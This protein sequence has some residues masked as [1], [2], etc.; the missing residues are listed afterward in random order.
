MSSPNTTAMHDKPVSIIIPIYNA[1]ENLGRCL[2]SITEQTLLDIEII[3]IDDGSDDGSQFLCDKYAQKDSRIKVVHT[4]HKGTASACNLGIN[5]SNGKY[6][7]FVNPYDWVEKQMFGH[8]YNLSLKSKADVVTSPY[9]LHKQN[10]EIVI[11]DDV[12]SINAR[13][14][15]DKKLTNKFAI[16]GFYLKSHVYCCSIYKKDF[17]TDNKIT[18][19]PNNKSNQSLAFLFL[20]YCH[21]SVFYI[22]RASFYHHFEYVD[23]DDN[24]FIRATELLNEHLYISEIIE[25]YSIPSNLAQIEIAKLFLDIN[26]QL[27]EG[28]S[29]FKQRK[30]YLCKASPIFNKYIKFFN[31]NT[32]LSKYEKKQ[33]INYAEH[34]EIAAILNRYNIH[35]KI[36]RYLFNIQ[37]KKKVSYIR[38][39]NFPIVFIKRT[40]EYR[41]CNIFN[42][43]IRRIR[44]TTEAPGKIKTRYHYIGIPLLKR[45]DTQEEI[46]LYFAGVRV[47]KKINIQAQLTAIIHR[48]NQLPDEIHMS[49]LSDVSNTVSASHSKTFPQ[50]KNSNYGKSIAI[51][52]TGPSIKYSPAIKNSKTIACNRAYEYFVDKDPTYIFAEDYF[53][54]SGFFEEMVKNKKSNIFLGCY[55]SHRGYNHQSIPEQFLNGENIYRYYVLFKALNIRAELEYNPIAVFGTVVHSALHFALY[56]NPETIYLL[57]CDT[58]SSGYSNKNLIQFPM[59]TSALIDGYTKFRAFRDAQYPNTRIVSVNPIGLRGIFED[60]YTEEFVKNNTEIDEFNLQLVNEI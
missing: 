38:I 43:P 18:F 33:L 35:M 21:M 16:T 29:S 59:N 32:Y 57:G 22:T 55:V 45:I 13:S 36:L 58:S 3:L 37:I 1:K 11:N 19:N 39:F 24:S 47:Y 27:K 25:K 10:G 53:G 48:L 8:L 54:V 4:E 56:T 20:V 15:F 7:G 12:N 31:A 44:K 49:Y 9:Y 14:L 2:D 41:T 52:A 23:T 17:L 28:C 6:I 46:K 51:L 40:N 30:E 42:I 26:R 5:I 60:V 50:F 34:P